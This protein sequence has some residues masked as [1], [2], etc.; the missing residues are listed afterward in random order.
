MVTCIVHF[1]TPGIFNLQIKMW[2][3]LVFP[4]K[5]NVLLFC[6]CKMSDYTFLFENAMF[7]VKICNKIKRVLLG[8]NLIVLELYDKQ[9]L[10]VRNLTGI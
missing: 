4:W 10:P 2:S 3:K 9:D 6:C 1:C 5:R 8:K 7:S